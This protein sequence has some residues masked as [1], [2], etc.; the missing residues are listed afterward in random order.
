[1][2]FPAGSIRKKNEF[3]GFSVSLWIERTDHAIQPLE[4]F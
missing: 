4:L 1:M 2:G 3:D